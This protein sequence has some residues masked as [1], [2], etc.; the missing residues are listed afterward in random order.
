MK[1]KAN[2]QSNEPIKNEVKFY[3]NLP[4]EYALY[5]TVYFFLVNSI[6]IHE[7]RVVGFFVVQKEEEVPVVSD[8]GKSKDKSKGKDDKPSRYYMYQVEYYKKNADGKD[9]LNLATVE[10]EELT[11]K[12]ENIEDVFEVIRHK[13][14][15]E[16]I[17]DY[18]IELTGAE[19]NE[20]YHKES[21]ETIKKELKRLKGLLDEDKNKHKKVK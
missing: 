9:M 7:G 18:G 16:L 11:T 14:I 20:K 2:V 8:K 10:A 19:V 4:T 12:R 1:N 15:K 6:E 5:Q 17:S 13:R 21:K 3:L